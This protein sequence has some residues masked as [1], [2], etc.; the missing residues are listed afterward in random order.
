M[1]VTTSSVNI[2]ISS[3]IQLLLPPTSVTI[4]SVSK[5][6]TTSS[7]AAFPFSITSRT[8]P[9]ITTQ[10]LSF[11]SASSVAVPFPSTSKIFTIDF[12]RP[13]GSSNNLDS[14]ITELLLMMTTS[15]I[16][17]ISS[18]TQLLT[19]PITSV[20]KSLTMSSSLGVIPRTSN[21]ISMTTIQHPSFTTSKDTSTIETVTTSLVAVPFPFT[22]DIRT[23]DYNRSTSIMNTTPTIVFQGQDRGENNPVITITAVI[24]SI[25]LLLLIVGIIVTS[26]IIVYHQRRKKRKSNL[27]V[28]NDDSLGYFNATYQSNT[29]NQTSTNVSKVPCDDISNPVYGGNIISIISI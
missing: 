9:I 20:M 26:C 27:V 16:I 28:L 17:H 1:T 8:T 10:Q 4:T 25:L 18:T 3:T 11:I 24:V 6:S 23:V 5:S 29:L 19:N 2:L 14:S 12:N 15:V 13:T 22:S 7:S 21:I